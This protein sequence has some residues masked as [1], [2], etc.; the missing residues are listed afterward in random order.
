M[1]HDIRR[2]PFADAEASRRLQ[3]EAFGGAAPVPD[4]DGW[5]PAGSR[6]W[7]AWVDGGLAARAT[8][9]SFTSWFHG[10]RVPTAG[11]GGVTV[12]AEHRGTGLLRPLVEAALAEAREH[13]EVVST[14]YPSAPGVYRGLGYEIVGSYDEI[15]VPLSALAA[16][17]RPPGVRTR[18][19]AEA[20]VP[21]VRAV[22]E[23][24]AAA[25]NGPLTR[26]E[27]PFTVD[28]ED[29]VGPDADYTGVTLAVDAAD[30]GVLGFVSWTRDAGYDRAGVLEVDDLVALSPDAARALWFVL[31]SF[32]TVVG[33]ARISTSGA[34][35]GADVS[36]LVLP[37]HAATATSRPYMLRLLDVPGALGSARLAAWTAEVPF[38]VVDPRTPDLEGSWVLR[39][40]DGAVRVDPDDAAPRTPA[41]RPVF[42]A[43]GLAQSYAGSQTC[44]NLRLAGQLHGPDGHDAVWDA[45][46]TGRPVHVRDY[47]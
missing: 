4:A 20:D 38:A 37:D 26:T 47:F 2:L 6:P 35:S 39:V 7:G 19:A 12:A 8:V 3:Q 18:R 28:P 41:D 10:A 14:L 45:L 17:R 46:W 21:A 13:G 1:S 31:A 36:R 30:G 23:R 5:P 29:L 32:G 25:Q 34:W 9:R 11:L 15:T 40:S 44:A 16:L 33:S 27:A 22:Y 24:W 43:G 42:T